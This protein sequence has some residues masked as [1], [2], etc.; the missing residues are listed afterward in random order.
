[1]EKCVTHASRSERST[2][3]EEVCTRDAAYGDGSATLYAMMK[4][5][6]ANYVV[7]KMIEIA[8][9]PQRKLLLQRIRPYMMQLRKYTYGKHILAKLEKFMIKSS[10]SVGTVNNNNELLAEK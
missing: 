4:D 3:I 6:Y 2:L 5:Q 8:E 7:Q 9:P 10:S 1:M